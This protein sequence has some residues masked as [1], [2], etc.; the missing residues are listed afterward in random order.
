[1][2]K[3]RLWNPQY[4][5]LMT[6]NIFASCG[7]YMVNT[8]LVSYL[9]GNEVGLSS[10]AAGIIAGMF[11]ITALISRPFCGIM[12]DRFNK[13]WML[14]AATLFMVAGAFGY[15]LSKALPFIVFARILHGIGFAINST[16]LISLV[17]QYVPQN[18][19]GEGLG[20]FGLA[21]VIASATA[22]GFGVM[23]A[24]LM[25]TGKV[26]WIAGIMCVG[27]IL[28]LIVVK[29]PGAKRTAVQKAASIG[30]KD[31]IA[32]EVLGYTCVSSM[33]S[34]SNGIVTSYLVLYGRELGIGNI[35]LYFTI[36]ALAMFLVR[37]VSGK[38][39]DKKG[40]YIVAFPGMALTIVSMLLLASAGRF[41]GGAFAAVMVSSVLK[42]LGQGAA[43]PSLQA[44][45]IKKV[46][47]ERSG[48]ATS[49]YYLGGDIGQGLAPMIAGVI[50]GSALTPLKGYIVSFN[51]TAVLLALAMIGLVFIYRKEKMA[52]RFSEASKDAA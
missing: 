28:L 37:P 4:V 48:S 27:E 36:N 15:G 33:F 42:A 21:N 52:K 34:F 8:M 24:E 39:M 50:V 20:Y 47:K 29:Y 14:R 38:L 35:S 51:M 25:G 49:T 18:K 45:C 40:M 32:V 43:Q 23:V 22:P 11:S 41:T 13:V 16:T 46:G 7:F 2:E 31:I 10:E 1:M 9:T 26:F 6:A 3:E 12:A 19:L 17:T 44:A 5:A 30:I